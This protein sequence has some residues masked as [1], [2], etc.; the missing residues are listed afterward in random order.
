MGLI[1]ASASPRRSDLLAQIGITPEKIIPADIDETP[2][3]TELPLSYVKRMADEKAA[4]VAQKYPNDVVLAADTIVMVGRRILGKPVNAKD[5]ARML[6]LLSGRRHSVCTAVCVMANQKARSRL[7]ETVVQFK[8][9]S[10]AEINGYLASGEWEGKA[11]A[12]AIQGRAEAFV[13]AINGNYSNIVGLPL[14]ETAGLLE[15]I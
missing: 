7:V 8:R 15:N 6:K 5:A 13:K 12:Y 1:L 9:L 2:G 3:K 11:G 14:M 4:L 10:E